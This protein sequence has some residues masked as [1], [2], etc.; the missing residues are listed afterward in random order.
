MTTHDT[1]IELVAALR[2]GAEQPGMG[3]L[4]QAADIIESFENGYPDSIGEILEV[5]EQIH[6]GELVPQWTPVQWA[7][8]ASIKMG[9]LSLRAAV[10]EGMDDPNDSFAEMDSE[11]RKAYMYRETLKALAV[12]LLDALEQTP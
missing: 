6:A 4:T 5:R 8:M 12:V 3:Y 10:T 11:E 1:R 7:I 2:R 9:D